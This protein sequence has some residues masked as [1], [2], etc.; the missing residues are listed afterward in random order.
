MDQGRPSGDPERWLRLL[1]VL[2]LVALL[3]GLAALQPA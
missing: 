2:A 3:L 1:I